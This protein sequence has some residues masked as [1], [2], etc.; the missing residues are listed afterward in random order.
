M[1]K[2]TDNASKVKEMSQNLF[3][4]Y[5]KAKLRTQFCVESMKEELSDILNIC[6][7]DNESLVARKEMI[8]GRWINIQNVTLTDFNV[9]YLIQQCDS[10]SYDSVNLIK[11]LEFKKYSYG[12]AGDILLKKMNVVTRDN[13]DISTNVSINDSSRARVEFIHSLFP[14]ELIVHKRK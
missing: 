6:M 4:E 11:D 7:F 13:D 12:L 5:E 1:T 14:D 3:D 10:I 8:I 9:E 2:K